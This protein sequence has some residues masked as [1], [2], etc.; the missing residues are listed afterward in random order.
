MHS[1]LPSS[2]A[3]PNAVRASQ[4]TAG[5]GADNR[6]RGTRGSG[7]RRAFAHTLIAGT[8]QARLCSREVDRRDRA[9]RNRA[10][11]PVSARPLHL[12]GAVEEAE[13]ALLEQRSAGFVV[14]GQAAVGEQVT[15]AAIQK[16]LCLLDD[17][18]EPWATWRSP[19]APKQE[20]P[21][22]LA[23]PCPS[24]NSGR[25]PGQARGHFP[26]TNR[27]NSRFHLV[28]HC[29]LLLSAGSSAQGSRRATYGACFVRRRASA[30][31]DAA[32]SHR[33][34]WR[35]CGGDSGGAAARN[36]RSLTLTHCHS[37]HVLHGC[38]LSFCS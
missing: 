18:C 5:V 12:A 27:Q 32:P 7:T 33:R 16:Q 4:G 2:G 8:S 20:P 1:R 23:R 31:A 11:R 9:V 25:A 26:S 13:H 22:R 28:G 38:W 35:G 14:V 6:A 15:V 21:P 29:S 36:K 3:P 24:P 37:T 34:V 17:G 30:P 10:T 19:P